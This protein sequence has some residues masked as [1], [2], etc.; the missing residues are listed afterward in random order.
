[1]KMA[2][3]VLLSCLFAGCEDDMPE[4]NSPN[5]VV[6]VYMGIDNNLA[7]EA[8]EQM[9]ALRRG[10]EA[11]ATED[12]L[13][14]YAD[15]AGAAP[16][17]SCMK[18]EAGR[19]VRQ[20]LRTYEETNSADATVFASV[21]EEVKAMYPTNRTTFG[22]IFFSHASGWLPAGTLNNAALRSLVI[23][24]GREMELVDFAQAIPDNCFEYI[25][26]DACFTAGIELTYELRNK[27]KYVL[28]SSAEI[29]SPGYTPVYP[30]AIGSLFREQADL[31]SFARA[32][33]NHVDRQTDNNRSATLSV[34][35]T[36]GLEALRDFVAAHCNT[37]KAVDMA[38]IQDFGRNNFR[39][40]F[41]DFEM[42][43]AALLN[44]EAER[45][46]L[47]ERIAAC[48]DYKVSTR[49]FM[50]DYGGFT[51]DHHSGLTTYIRQNRY[52]HLN[53]AYERLAWSR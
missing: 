24:N 41:F 13:Y 18:R 2:L 50:P 6:L 17:L 48:V 33:F 36:A 45:K 39:S 37:T 16:S 34:V 3:L 40:L 4:E 32:L 22:L 46:T 5:H 51:I 11:A 38:A 9:E 25:V 30:E 31:Q 10:W 19:A 23:D 42:Y 8:Q 14:V 29:L 52:P 53:S 15:V 35:R 21:I 12:R 43:Y 26:F 20:T 49:T 47:S 44:T 1:M 28:G 27:T 7:G